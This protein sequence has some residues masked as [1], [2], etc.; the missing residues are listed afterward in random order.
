[1]GLGKVPPAEIEYLEGHVSHDRTSILRLGVLSAS[2]DGQEFQTI[3]FA[4]TP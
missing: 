2:T 4:Y 3:S 1:V